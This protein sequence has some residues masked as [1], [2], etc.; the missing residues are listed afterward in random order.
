MSTTD[1]GRWRRTSPFAILFFFG[2]IFRLIA[3]NAWQSLAPLVALL[4]AY[5]GNIVNKLI[6]ASIGFSVFISAAALLSYWFFRFRIS[7][8]SVL[9]RHGVFKKKQLDIK[10]DRLQGINTEQGLIYRLLGLVTVNFD[11]AGS[12]GNEGNLPAVTQ[13]FAD[14]LRARLEAPSPAHITN[15]EDKQS[16]TRTDELVRFDWRDMLRIGLADRRALIVFAVIGPFI[17]RMDDHIERYLATLVDIAAV[18]GVELDGISGISIAVAVF[19]IVVFLFIVVSIAAAFL[20]YNNFRLLLQGKTLRSHAGL[21]TAYEHSMD[22]GKIQ[23]LRLQQG[24]ALRL[25][26]RFQLTAHQAI[27]ARKGRRKA[28]E[29]PVITA[30]IGDALHSRFLAPDGGRLSLNP[31]SSGFVAI[32]PYSVRSKILF[33]G[34]LPALLATVVLM[35]PLGSLALFFLLW[36]PIVAA[37][38]YQNWKRAG[39][40]HDDE[41]II[42]RSGLLGYRTVSLLF[43]KVQRVTVSQSRYQRRKQLATLQMYLASGSVKVPYIKHEKAKQLRDYILYKVETSRKAWY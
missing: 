38:A 37:A 12:T 15:G 6:F 4:V 14:S 24:V 21:S 22:L 7:A 39:Y 2:R 9:I 8:D 1:S 25:M 28:F 18:N 41:E 5:E 34:L 36:L 32:S 27:S 31:A 29:V 11:T 26:K 40:V 20:R 10:F 13:R 43:R 19:F 33:A 16:E 23:T 30:E 3:K 17:E 35:K 42:R